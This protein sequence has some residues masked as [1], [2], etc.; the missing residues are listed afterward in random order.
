MI[1]LFI[2]DIENKVYI[3]NSNTIGCINIEDAV[4]AEA[5]ID[6]DNGTSFYFDINSETFKNTNQGFSIYKN[7]PEYIK[8]IIAKQ[9]GLRFNINMNDITIYDELKL[10]I[11]INNLFI[12]TQQKDIERTEV[13]IKSRDS[14]QFTFTCLTKDLSKVLEAIIECIFGLNKDETFEFKIESIQDVFV[15]F[16]SILFDNKINLFSEKGISI[17]KDLSTGKI[18]L[19]G[20]ENKSKILDL[21]ENMVKDFINEFSYLLEHTFEEITS[22]LIDTLCLKAMNPPEQNFE[23]KRNYINKTGKKP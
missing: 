20:P 1:I 12:I 9:L 2:V 17:D 13:I 22:A 5:I 18:S 15:L 6:I 3:V 19:N 14:Q 10:K 16:A 21:T 8:T 7:I 4:N 11:D 23:I